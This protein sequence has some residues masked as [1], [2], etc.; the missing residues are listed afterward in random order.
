LNRPNYSVVFASFP[1]VYVSGRQI[2]VSEMCHR[3]DTHVIRFTA[4]TY[5]KPELG[6]KGEIKV[7]GT[8]K[9]KMGTGWRG[10]NN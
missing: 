10:K 5:H 1:H 6:K 9:Q 4:L 7:T 3:K 8:V 2:Y